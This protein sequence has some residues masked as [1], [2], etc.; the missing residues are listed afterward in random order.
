VLVNVIQPQRIDIVQRFELAG[1]VP[2][3]AGQGVK[4]F[5]FA[6]IDVVITHGSLPDPEKWRVSGIAAREFCPPSSEL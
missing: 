3:A 1:R 6:M 2:P 5:N 4:F